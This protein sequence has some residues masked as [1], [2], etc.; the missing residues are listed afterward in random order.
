[1]SATELFT[2]GRALV[3]TLRAIKGIEVGPDGLTSDGG[4][5]V[6]DGGSPI[7]QVKTGTLT[8]NPA[9]LAA[10][11]SAGTDATLTGVAAGDV[12]V[13]IPP[14]TLDTGLV[15]NG[16]VA[17]ANKVTIYLFN[18]TASAVDGA[19]LVWTYLW[20]DLT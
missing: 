10:G 3:G 18:P 19:S 15:F 14:A 7:L 20:F 6:G 4:V 1:M 9:S 13:L 5:T 8:V 2:R 12:V 11:A 17:G 16:A